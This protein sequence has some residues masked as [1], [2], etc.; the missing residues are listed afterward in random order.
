MARGSPRNIQH[1]SQSSEFIQRSNLRSKMAEAARFMTVRGLDCWTPLHAGRLTGR[2]GRG[3]GRP[4]ERHVHSRPGP[5]PRTDRSRSHPRSTH[6]APRCTAF[7]ERWSAQPSKWFARPEWPDLG[8]FGFG[9]SLGIKSRCPS[10]PIAPSRCTAPRTPRKRKGKCE[11]APAT[12]QSSRTLAR[13]CV[14]AG[15]RGR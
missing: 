13:G 5:G 4:R 10:L 2:C 9:V 11:N 12:S 3:R 6:H 1:G 7:R 15:S 14:M 8:S